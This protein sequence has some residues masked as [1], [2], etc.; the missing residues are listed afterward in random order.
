M[1]GLKIFEASSELDL[2]ENPFL[3]NMLT[4]DEK[5]AAKGTHGS[6]SDSNRYVTSS[7]PSTTN[8]RTPLVHG[9]DAHIN[10]SINRNFSIKLKILGL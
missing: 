1:L 5:D 9:D 6:P 10:K 3:E 8:A 4:S 7:D 2:S